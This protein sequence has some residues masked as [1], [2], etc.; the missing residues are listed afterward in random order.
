MNLVQTDGGAMVMMSAGFMRA[1]SWRIARGL[2]AGALVVLTAT[3]VEAQPTPAKTPYVTLQQFPQQ[4]GN[5]FGSVDDSITGF[6]ALAQRFTATAILQRAGV[7]AFQGLSTDIPEFET[8]SNEASSSLDGVPIPSGST[9][10]LYTFDPKLEIFTPSQRPMAPSISQNAPTN[11]RNVLTLGFSYSYLDYTHFNEFPS[12]NVFIQASRGIPF[13]ALGADVDGEL[14]DV[15]YFN[16]KLRQ[17]FYGF[18]AQ[19]GILENFDVGIFVPIV[20]TDFKGKAV[21]NFFAQ[22]TTDEMLPNGQ[23]LPKGTLLELK[24]DGQLYP[25]PTLGS[26]RER[27]VDEVFA[28]HSG[29][30]YTKSNTGIGDIILRTKYYFG[31]VGPAELG[32]LLNTSLPTGD[33]DNLEGV[34]SVRFDPRVVASMANSIL[35]GHANMGFHADV[36]DSDRDRFDY[37]VGGEFRATAWLT[38]MMDHVARLQVKG[39]DIHKF[40]LVPGIK[41]NPYRDLI[42]GFNAIL[43]LNREGLTTDWTPNG[44][45]EVSFH[46]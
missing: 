46:F 10:V 12:D 41:M 25:F 43:P 34:G 23:V 4:F 44:T 35:A 7:P 2:V 1:K 15:M 3:I 19:Y 14:V 33:E 8:F 5:A 29:V 27:D 28:P 36:D 21:S 37:S 39:D 17:Q 30:S 13:S 20:Q 45:A 38:F 32:A 6:F 31:M 9:S 22:L 42:F 18:S 40:E 11:G 16:F 24:N 26:I